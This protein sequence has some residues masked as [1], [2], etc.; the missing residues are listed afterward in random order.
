IAKDKKNRL[1][2][3]GRIPNIWIDHFGF[4]FG[5]GRDDDVKARTLLYEMGLRNYLTANDAGKSLNTAGDAYLPGVRHVMDV[6]PE[7]LHYHEVEIAEDKDVREKFFAAMDGW[8]SGE[9]VTHV[10]AV[11]GENV[12]LTGESASRSRLGLPGMQLDFLKALVEYRE[13]KSAS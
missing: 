1:V 4:W 2:M 3:A 13:S 7:E 8:L 6:Q 5:R 11:V 9:G 12:T 10:L